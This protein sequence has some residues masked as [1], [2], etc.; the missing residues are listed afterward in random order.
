VSRA[1]S[2]ILKC[3]VFS[4]LIGQTAR[5]DPSTDP[6]HRVALDAHIGFAT[7]YGLA[8][9]ALDITPIKQASIS[10]GYGAGLAGPQVA[11]MARARLADLGRSTDAGIGFGVSYGD[12]K[13]GLDLP[14]SRQYEFKDAIWLNWEAV[15][16]EDRSRVTRMRLYLGVAVR[17]HHGACL[18]RDFGG[19]LSEGSCVED[20][21]YV[22][23]MPVLPFIALSVGLG[24]PSR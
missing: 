16:I 12:F 2:L 23:R 24:L 20:H 13:T 17:V 19:G 14:H 8:G 22:S 10:L 21:E 15:F 11:A 3:F 5:A 18:L 7:P 9:L 6:A 1:R 4:L